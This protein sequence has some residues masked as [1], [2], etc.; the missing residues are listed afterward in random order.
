MYISG[1]TSGGDEVL[2]SAAGPVSP[3]R[4]SPFRKR[5]ATAPSIGPTSKVIVVVV[6]DALNR[7][8]ADTRTRV[9]TKQHYSTRNPNHL[10]L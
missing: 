6:I 3:T 9:T 10:T 5:V 2:R 7:A 1:S 4:A 8:R